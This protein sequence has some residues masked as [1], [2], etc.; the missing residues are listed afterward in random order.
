MIGTE[1]GQARFPSFLFIKM[2]YYSK[3]PE[4]YK[5]AFGE[6][7][8]CDHP[9]YSR[10]TLYRFGQKGLAVIQQRFDAKTKQT[11]WGEIDGWIANALY[12]EPRFHA[13]M[14]KRAAE[15]LN[16]LYPTATVRQA[17]WA[18]RMK[19]LKKERWETV[20]DRRDI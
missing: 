8:S 17:M 16:G 9:V 5:Q 20:F 12:L 13:Y 1:G 6:I 11:R 14:R 18:A 2:R 15:P 4:L 7:Y 3:A 10:C 19:P